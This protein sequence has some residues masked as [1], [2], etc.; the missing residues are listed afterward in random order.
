MSAGN[1]INKYLLPT[2]GLL[3]ATT[4]LFAF[5]LQYPF[6]TTFPIGGD[7]ASHIRAARSI[8][9][10]FSSPGESLFT[11]K[12]S[13]YPLSYLFLAS[14]KILPVS[15]P[16]RFVW[17]AAAGHVLTGFS[18]AA[19]LW[20]ISSWRAAA[21]GLAIW[22][23]TPI[24]ITNHF[25]DGTIPQLW[26]LIFLFLSFERL[27]AGSTLGTL[28][29][30]FLT[31]LAHPLSGFVLITSLIMGV[32]PLFLVRHRLP[33]RQ[34]ALIKYTSILIAIPPALVLYKVFKISMG[35]RLPVVEALSKDFFLFDILKSKFAPWL[36]LSLPGIAILVNKLRHNLP[37]T[38]ALL[39]FFWLSFL[40]TINSAFNVGLWENRFRTYFIAAACLAAGLALPELIRHALRPVGVRLL[41]LA[42][43]FGSLSALTWRD[44]AAVYRFYEY[45]ANNARLPA[46]A[47]DAI[48]WM[49][50][51]LPANS[52]IASSA[53]SRHAEWIPALTSFKWQDLN[54]KHAL[55]SGQEDELPA[56][57]NTDDNPFTHIIF[58]TRQE[59]VNATMLAHPDLFPVVFNNAAAVIIKLP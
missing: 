21:A 49:S 46:G 29:M 30:L 51:N 1:A 5:A 47:Q 31:V 39:S 10:F 59:D 23:L 6:S 54:S 20:R 18:L 55:L 17:W 2:A 40:L 35:A 38:T 48:N 14:T 26:S 19:L 44:N 12:T 27:I 24:D 15:W 50:L 13:N 42:L 16:G 41:F 36:V 4:I 22:A 57:A 43:L 28:I 25:E 56:F 32:C 33:A 37:A 8:L 52:Y 11:L 3:T 34:T 9:N 58:L 7:A 53:A 45:P